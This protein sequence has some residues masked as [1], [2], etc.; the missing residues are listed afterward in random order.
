MTKTKTRQLLMPVKQARINRTKKTE[1]VREIN[2]MIMIG[3]IQAMRDLA[4]LC[5]KGN[6]NAKVFAEVC[7]WKEQMMT[8]RLRAL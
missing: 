4:A 8:Q 6:E 1:A 5:R 7:E 2:A 3:Y